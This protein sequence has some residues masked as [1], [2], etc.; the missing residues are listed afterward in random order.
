MP[1]AVIVTVRGYSK[2]LPCAV[3]INRDFGGI[4]QHMAKVKRKFL[5]AGMSLVLPGIGQLAA[6]K[7][8]RGSLMLISAIVLFVM[9]VWE[10]AR[11]Y[12]HIAAQI[13][14]NDTGDLR[15]PTGVVIRFVAYIVVLM[16]I[17]AWSVAD[18]FFFCG[19]EG[20]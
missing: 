16:V 8:I 17:Y 9:T 15:F 4:K 10:L 3:I 13:L 5:Y 7:Y 6:G 18:A 14:N 2:L 1:D 11:M 12:L 20:E 19:K